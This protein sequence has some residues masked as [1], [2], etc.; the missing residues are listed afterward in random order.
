M[1]AIQTRGVGPQA[2][3][4]DDGDGDWPAV[5][6]F[7]FDPSALFTAAE[8]VALRASAVH[9]RPPAAAEPLSLQRV[10]TAETSPGNGLGWPPGRMGVF[11]RFLHDTSYLPIREVAIAAVLGLMAGV[12]GR[13]Y[14]THTGKDLALYLILVAKSGVGK[15]AMHD[16]IPMMLELANEPL[17]R[18]FLR[19]D[20]FASGEAL[21]KALLKEPG[22]LYLQGEFGRKLKRM[23][24]PTDAPM[25]TFRTTMTNAFGKQHLEGKAYSNADNS[26]DGVDWPALSFLGETTPT[27]FL[28]CLTPDMMHDGFLSRFLVVSYT[29]GQPS[30]NR[31]RH[32]T[33]SQSDLVAWRDLVG[34]TSK[35]LFTIDA[36]EALSAIPDATAAAALE[37]FDDECRQRLNATDDEAERPIWTRAHLKALKIASLLAVA[38]NYL[39]P[40]IRKEHVEWALQL[41]QRDIEA[42][43]ANQRNGDIGSGDDTRQRKLLAFI[44]EYLTKPVP[45][46]YRVPSQMSKDGFV[47]RKYL[48]VRSASLPAFCNH[49]LGAT[50]AMEEAL[51]SL[52]LNG[53]MMIVKKDKMVEMYN[54]HGEAYRVLEL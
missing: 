18:G 29:G 31:A 5:T 41:I 39:A 27:A 14:R 43:Q 20:D 11:A 51:R 54:F 26:L 23:A 33:L 47:A 16:G 42:F 46:S 45:D 19:A 10:A 53:N 30:P 44:R 32:A 9:N 48:Q 40:V 52:V 8:A 13:A 25:Q 1:T 38:D 37:Q 2:L 3:A 36:P 4:Q 6:S 17:A 35:H 7:D 49:K 34:H 24:N 12:C 21:H 50:K 28:E 22:F 15:D